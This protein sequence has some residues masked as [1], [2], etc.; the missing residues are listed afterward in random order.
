M[1]HEMTLGEVYLPPLLV[2]AFIA[3]L[4][5]NGVSMMTAKLGGYQWIASPA[6]FEL[7]LFVLISALLGLVIPIV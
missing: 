5:A 7:S 4:V 3:Y 6:I 2:I 1:P